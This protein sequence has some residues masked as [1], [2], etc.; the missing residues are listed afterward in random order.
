VPA[1]SP[2]PRRGEADI[3]HCHSHP[4]FWLGTTT[5][6]PSS[7]LTVSYTSVMGGGPGLWSPTMPV[8]ETT[9]ENSKIKYIFF[10][11][12]LARL[13]PPCLTDAPRLTQ[14]ARCFGGR[15]RV[16]CPNYFLHCLLISCLCYILQSKDL[17]PL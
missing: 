16:S 14:L 3:H 8:G 4:K 1:E 2:D 5:D 12:I 11:F 15:G 10:N 13:S 7:S 6:S 9:R 17:Q